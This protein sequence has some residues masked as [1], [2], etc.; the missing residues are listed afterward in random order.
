MNWLQIVSI[1]GILL[2]CLGCLAAIWN[3]RSQRQRKDWPEVVAF[4]GLFCLIFVSVLV[5]LGR[6]T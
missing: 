3:R 5:A 2:F 6:G 1:A 4:S